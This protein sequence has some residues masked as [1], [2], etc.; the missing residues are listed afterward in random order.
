MESI[1]TIT[2]YYIYKVKVLS[3]QSFLY[4]NMCY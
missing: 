3:I 2:I 4:K 1:M